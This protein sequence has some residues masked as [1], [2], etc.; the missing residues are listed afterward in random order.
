[1]KI[2]YGTHF[3]SEDEPCLAIYETSKWSAEHG[4]NRRYQTVHVIRDGHPA[5]FVRDMGS[6]KNFK[7][8]PIWVVGGVIGDKIY[9]EET[10]GSLRE[11]AEDMRLHTGMDMQEYPDLDRWLDT[12]KKTIF[13]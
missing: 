8:G 2:R 10:V 11:H 9:I 6:S 1:M 5:E 4:E 3:V 12:K 13:S 7:A